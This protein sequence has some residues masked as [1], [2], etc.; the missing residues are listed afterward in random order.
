[1][2]WKKYETQ[3]KKGYKKAERKKVRKNGEEGVGANNID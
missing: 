1:M 3:E 2:K